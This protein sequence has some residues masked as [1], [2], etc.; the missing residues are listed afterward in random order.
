MVG[1]FAGDGVL[2]RPENRL[3][4]FSSNPANSL[5]LPLFLSVAFLFTKTCFPFL[6]IYSSFLFFIPPLLYHFFFFRFLIFVSPFYRLIVVDPVLVQPS[7]T[8]QDPGEF[9]G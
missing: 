3:G 9:H 5:S 1:L 2:G 7:H 6:F 8:I 4:P